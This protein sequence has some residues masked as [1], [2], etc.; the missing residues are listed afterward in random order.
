VQTLSGAG[1]DESPV[2]DTPQAQQMVTE[3]PNVSGPAFHDDNLQA[4]VVVEVNVGSGQDHRLSV[5]LGRNKFLRELGPM[6]VVNHGQGTDN[7]S[8][9]IGFLLNQILAY[10]V[11]NGLR[12]VL[13]AF[14]ANG[15]V[16]PL[17]EAALQGQSC[18]YQISHCK[19]HPPGATSPFAALDN[20]GANVVARI[21]KSC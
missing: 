12:A 16:E 3:L 20:R 5:M 14:S 7:G 9:F 13:I 17:E 1:D 15:L 10:E 2:L 11:S 8:V 4:I 18:S 6:V 21:L 19:L